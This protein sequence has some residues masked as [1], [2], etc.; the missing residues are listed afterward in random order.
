M[1]TGLL[2][3]TSFGSFPLLIVLLV[4]IS[5]TLI[6]FFHK[7]LPCFHK[8]FLFDRC[9]A[10]K[11]PYFIYVL[12]VFSIISS[13][14]FSSLSYSLSTMLLAVYSSFLWKFGRFFFA[15]CNMFL[16]RQLNASFIE[17]WPFT[18]VVMVFLSSC[19]ITTVVSSLRMVGKWSYSLFHFISSYC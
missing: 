13:H 8:D 14:Y 1:G 12:S 3:L 6:F 4:Q 17:Y 2:L 5:I 11:L 10:L 19:S 9:S 18:L 15:A 7:I 16:V